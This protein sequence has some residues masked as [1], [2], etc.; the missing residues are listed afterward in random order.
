[1]GAPK[2]KWTSEEE[3]ALRAGVEKYGSGKWQTILKDPEFAV[4]LAS[5]SNVDLKDKWRNLMSVT[6]GGQGS[7]TPRVKSI[8]AVPLSSV[9]PLSPTAPAAGM[10][11]KSEA[12]IPSADIVIYSPKSISASARNHSPRCDYDDMILEALT[13]LRDPNG[14]DVTTIASFMEER[15]QLPPSFRRTLGS[16]L[17]RLVSQEKIIRIRNS[18]KLKDMAEPRAAVLGPRNSADGLKQLWYN[19]MDAASLET[20]NQASM[21]AAMKM[22]EADAMAASAE[23]A[24]R[25]AEYDTRLAEEADIFLK[26]VSEVFGQ[27]SPPDDADGFSL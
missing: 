26:A 1:M 13:A 14:I 15:H 16:K 8:A 18:Y 5:R 21:A 19:P 27:F 2:Q 23:E 11:V 20:I 10:L 7:K 3:G 4:C 9:S 12:T 22:A 25:E 6:A 24:A 17:K